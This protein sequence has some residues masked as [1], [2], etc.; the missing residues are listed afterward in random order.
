MKTPRAVV[1]RGSSTGRNLWIGL[2]VMLKIFSGATSGACQ[3][4]EGV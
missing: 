3:A 1:I 2:Y 4:A